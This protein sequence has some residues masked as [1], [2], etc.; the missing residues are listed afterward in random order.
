MD[1]YNC[2]HADRHLEKEETETFIL[3]ACCQ[4]CL[5]AQVF[6]KFQELLPHCPNGS[7]HFKNIL[8]W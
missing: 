3:D 8:E 5:H 2:L 6:A 1:H 4:V 7:R